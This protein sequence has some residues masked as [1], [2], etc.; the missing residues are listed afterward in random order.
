[1]KEIDGAMP[2]LALMGGRIEPP[3]RVNVL[4]EE[5]G[6]VLTVF[7]TEV[8]PNSLKKHIR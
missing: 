8:L 5:R 6:E 4:D 1:M 2:P 7:M 3:D